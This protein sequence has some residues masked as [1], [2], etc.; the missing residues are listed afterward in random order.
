MTDLRTRSEERVKL[1]DKVYESLS[2][3]IAAGEWPE[4]TRIP[5]EVELAA[6]YS[7]SR[8]VVREAL[9]RLRSE[10]MI[11]SRR[12]SGSIVLASNGVQGSVGSYKPIEN[13]ADLIHTFE[14]RQSVECDAT[15]IA[16]RRAS[17][18]QV[19]AVRAAHEAFTDTTDD[20]A[21]GDLDLRFHLAIAKATGNEMFASTL[22]MLHS[23][24]ILGMRLSGEFR[25]SDEG[26][27]VS[28]VRREHQAIVDAIISHDAHAAYAAMQEHLRLSRH[29]ILGFEVANDWQRP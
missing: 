8:P 16:A 11:D 1:S 7:V 6:I 17:A 19:A 4:G 14:F 12:G 25:S 24:I 5:T 26:S 3:Q 20:E 28:I 2:G 22:E 23:Q 18:D 10:G 9:F 21:F 27:R 13:I 15:A 29:R